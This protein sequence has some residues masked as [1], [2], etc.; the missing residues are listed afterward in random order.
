MPTYLNRDNKPKRITSRQLAGFF[1]AQKEWFSA[2]DAYN[3]EH[4]HLD[5]V[6]YLWIGQAVHSLTGMS[7]EKP[8]LG[9]INK[10]LTDEP[11]LWDDDG[12]YLTYLSRTVRVS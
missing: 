12:N 4:Y 10:W 5:R 6:T 2:N 11:W 9:E 1:R 8:K 7:G 3:K